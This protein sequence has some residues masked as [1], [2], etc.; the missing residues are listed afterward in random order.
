MSR[1]KRQTICEENCRTDSVR[2]DWTNVNWN[3]FKMAT[4]SFYKQMTKKECFLEI[5]TA[6]IVIMSLVGMYWYFIDG[7]FTNKPL[8]FESSELVIDK[9]EYHRGDS[10]YAYWKFTKDTD[11]TAVI[12]ANI[13]DG[14]VWYLPQ[15]QGVRAKGSYDKLDVLAN[16]PQTIPDG[17]YHVELNVEY[18]INPLKTVRYHFT[19]TKFKIH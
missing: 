6:F 14:V 12:S 18:K 9:P 1:R 16:I 15:V 17:E 11:A 4:I 10:V 2:Y 19:T 3:N 5:S 7:T 13:I 8:S